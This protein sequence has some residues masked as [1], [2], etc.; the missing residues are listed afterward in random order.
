MS[1][2]TVKRAFE[3]AQSGKFDGLRDIAQALRQEGCAD[4]AEHLRSTFLRKQLIALM[5]G[6][7]APIEGASGR[8]LLQL[9]V[10]PD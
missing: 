1:S 6:K 7:T 4:V 8:H 9:Y 10:E 3:L 2:G 5:P